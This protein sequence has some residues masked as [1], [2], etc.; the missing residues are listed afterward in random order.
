MASYTGPTGTVNLP[1][2]YTGP[3]GTV[4]YSVVIQAPF[5][6]TVIS[7]YTAQGN[8]LVINEVYP[9]TGSTAVNQGDSNTLITLNGPT[10]GN[11]GT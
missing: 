4:S 7:T 5:D 2:V 1:D 9:V 6:P 3:T 11:T 10:G 8:L